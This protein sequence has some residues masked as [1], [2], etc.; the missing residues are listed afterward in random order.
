MKSR[1]D[2]VDEASDLYVRYHDKQW[3]VP[4]YDDRQ[5]FEFLTL[6]SAQAGLSWLTVLKKRTGYRKAFA[7]FDPVKVANF[8]Q[9]DINNL[10]R[11]K[12]IIRNRLK[13]E[14][15]VNNAN[16]FLSIQKEFGTFSNYQWQFVK[17]R[18]K[19][20]SWQNI[21]DVPP[22]SAEALLFSNDLRARGFKFIG[23]TIIYSHMQAVGMV[24]DH[25]TGCF[26]YEEV[27]SLSK[28]SELAVKI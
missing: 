19:Q 16:R 23:P 21:K 17:N 22:Q 18:P 7:N 5:I 28:N 1:C 15:A 14:A 11:N 10:L 25:L 13:I 8:S 20:N 6:E 3:G 27:R 4:L 24:N 26:R 9:K 12:D 2:W